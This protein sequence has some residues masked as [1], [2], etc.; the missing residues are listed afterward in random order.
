MGKQE[1]NQDTLLLYST[2][3]ALYLNDNA[4]NSFRD[5]GVYIRNSDKESQKIYRAVMKRI[6]SYF[7]QLNKIVEEHSEFL[8]DIFSSLDDIIEDAQ[9][10]YE[11][12]L[13]DMYLDVDKEQA[14]FLSK[15]DLSRSLV[16]ISVHGNKTI[17]ANLSKMIDKPYGSLAQYRLTE[18]LRVADNLASWVFRHYDM[19]KISEEKK[20]LAVQKMNELVQI[21]VGKEAFDKS[22]NKAVEQN[23]LH[24]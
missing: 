14:E 2:Y 20:K 19:D 1:N 16:A 23:G 15:L 7:E 12:F 6:N 17:N 10:E 4:C 22:Y 18:I 24:S 9:H 5:L 3:V 11:S 21:L 8:S 13:Y